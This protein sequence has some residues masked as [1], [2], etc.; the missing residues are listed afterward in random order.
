MRYEVVFWVYDA[1]GEIVT[2]Y[3]RKADAVKH[4]SQ[5]GGSWRRGRR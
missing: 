2:H 4:A 5:I 3:A 1:A